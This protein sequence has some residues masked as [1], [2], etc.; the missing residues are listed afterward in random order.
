MSKFSI[1]VPVYN[2]E[3]YLEK[4]VNSILRQNYRDYEL[5][6]VDDGSTDNSGAICDRILAENKENFNIRVVHQE[7]KGLGGARNTGIDVAT[8]EYLFFI[9]SDDTIVDSTLED[10]SDYIQNNDVDILTFDIVKVDEN[11]NQLY[12]IYGSSQGETVSTTDENKALILTEHSACNKVIRRSLF[13][14]KNI[15]FPER[16]WFEDLATIFKLFPYAKMGYINKAYYVYLERTGS[17]MNSAKCDKN[18]DMIT[19]LNST[20]EFYKENG[21]YEKYFDELEYVAAFHLYYLTS[22]RV[23][24]IDTKHKLL[25]IFREYMNENFPNFKGN[26][27]LGKKEK[28]I[29]SLLSK[30]LYFVINL[31]FKVKGMINSLRK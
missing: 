26:K 19:A 7:N 8:G 14:D 5:I 18:I 22:I 11:G 12:F 25:R 23:M 24:R 2:V 10:L 28:I 6:L 15:R 9:D 20:L 3:E 16:L 1:I 17:I 30:K 31:I 29:I 4:C 27:Y 21:L 13:T